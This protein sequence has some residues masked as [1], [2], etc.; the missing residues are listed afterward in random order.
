MSIYNDFYKQFI[1]EISKRVSE[2]PVDFSVP[3]HQDSRAYLGY[4][5][6]RSGIKYYSE[7]TSRGYGAGYVGFIVGVYLDGPMYEER[8]RQLK[9]S[10][11]SIESKVQ[12]S[13]TWLDTGRAGRIFFHLD[14]GIGDKTKWSKIIEWEIDKLQK[15]VEVFKPHIQDL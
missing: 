12:S 8:F 9:I 11:M 13:L 14:Q 1:P 5:T 3:S 15:I 4:K 6:G 10:R 7:Y 2:F